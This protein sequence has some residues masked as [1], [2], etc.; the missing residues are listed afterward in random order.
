MNTPTK[1]S[2]LIG[3]IMKD[4]GIDSEALEE[5]FDGMAD[6][7]MGGYDNVYEPDTNTEVV[8]IWILDN[9][10]H[11]YLCRHFMYTMLEHLSFDYDELATRVSDELSKM[12]EDNFQPFWNDVFPDKPLD[13]VVKDII[14]AMVNGDV[15]PDDEDAFDIFNKP[16]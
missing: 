8:V 16:T 2:T 14:Y 10:L 11:E 3:R 9:T 4:E 5:E 6:Y 13:I 1:L 12:T 15:C 7:V